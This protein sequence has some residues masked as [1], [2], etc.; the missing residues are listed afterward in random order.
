MC[1]ACLDAH[2]LLSVCCHSFCE[3]DQLRLIGA[4]EVNETK[5]MI[6]DGSILTPHILKV[7]AYYEVRGFVSLIRTEDLTLH[8]PIGY[9]GH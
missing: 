7:Q 8:G 2:L 4:E 1:R 5:E 9:L 3:P 6:R